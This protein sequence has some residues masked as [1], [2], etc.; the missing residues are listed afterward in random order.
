M[1]QSTRKFHRAV[2]E[3]EVLSEEPIPDPYDLDTLLYDITDGH[4]SGRAKTTVNE[5]VD[6]SRMAKLLEEQASDPGFFSLTSEGE[7]DENFDADDDDL[8]DEEDDDE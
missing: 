7:D 1:T 2:I 5:E 6:G 3:I 4:C 8:D